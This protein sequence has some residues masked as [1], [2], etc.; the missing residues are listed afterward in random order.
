M[1][2]GRRKAVAL[3]SLLAACTVAAVVT[4]GDDPPPLPAEPPPLPAEPLFGPA[5]SR[6]PQTLPREEPQTFFTPLDPEPEQTQQKP[7]PPP[8]TT[9]QDDLQ[10]LFPP[11]PIDLD[12]VPPAPAPAVETISSLD[13]GPSSAPRY[14][15]SLGGEVPT[16]SIDWV[17][18]ETILVGQEG[19]FELVIRN[20]GPAAIEKIAISQVI[21]EGFELKKATPAPQM[22]NGR[23]AWK[24]ERLAAQ[25]E[26]RISLRLLPRRVGDARTNAHLTFSTS[27]SSRFQVVEPKLQLAVEAPEST[28]VGN[29]AIFNVTVQNPGTGPTKNAVIKVQ[30]PEELARVGNS[31]TYEIGTLNPGESRSIRVLADVTALGKHDCR[32]I[33]TAENGLSDETAREVVGLQA[34]FKLDV[35]GPRFRYVGR[36]AS[37]T[38]TL[39]NDGTAAAENVQIRTAVP[40]SFDFVR[41]QDGRFDAPSRTVNWRVPRLDA[42]QEMKIKYDLKALKRGEH[43]MLARATADRGISA[44]KDYSTKVEGISAVLLEVVDAEDPIE[45]GAETFYEILVTNQGTDFATNVVVQAELPDGLKLT[46]LQGPTRGGANGQ[47][48]SFAPLPKLAPRA[49]AIYRIRV[50]GAKPGDLR[51]KVQAMADA[52][53]APVY[54]LESTKVYQD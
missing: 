39:R 11:A 34:R 33:A 42:G 22:E 37:Y 35:E 10:S 9:D 16:L 53:K 25:Q 3:W 27:T 17:T 47:T 20:R 45:V 19:D 36:P 41:S 26:Y 28:V 23:P 21:P 15:E 51:I 1:R 44:L 43:A 13:R 24:I 4:A 46:G 49:D 32:F 18:P 31:D 38:V 8:E 7:A 50:R 5:R 30:L 52:L 6:P 12:G 48:V 29:Q 54:E 14:A 2:K 40:V